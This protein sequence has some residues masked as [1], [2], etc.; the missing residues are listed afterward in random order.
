MEGKRFRVRVRHSAADP[1]EQW[2][3][4]I[5]YEWEYLMVADG[6]ITGRG[7]HDGAPHYETFYEA[8]YSDKQTRT[9][10]ATL[11][12]FPELRAPMEQKDKNW[13]VPAASGGGWCPGF[14]TA[15]WV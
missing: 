2:Y 7:L 5:D 15:R 4:P 9:W 3:P 11:V 8:P 6:G 13:C 14:G 10:T 12:S 1:F